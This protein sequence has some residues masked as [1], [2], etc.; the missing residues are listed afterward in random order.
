MTIASPMTLTFIQ[1]HK[2]VSNLT[3]FYLA[4]SQAIFK[5]LHVFKFGMTVDLWIPDMIMLILMTLTLMQ[6]HRG[7]SKAKKSALRALG[8]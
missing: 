7:S 1:G 6:G 3:T 8:N 5:L 4:I 2:C